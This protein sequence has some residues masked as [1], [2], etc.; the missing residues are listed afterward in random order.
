L[1]YARAAAGRII[2]WIVRFFYTEPIFRARCGSVGDRLSIEMLPDVTGHLRL[3][4]GSNVRFGG[5]MGVAAGRI[6]DDP[7]IVLG[8]GVQFGHDV[9]IAANKE[10]IVESGVRIGGGSRVLDTDG[11]PRNAALRAANLP[12]PPDEIRPVRIGQNAAIG[13]QS[14][15]LKG[16]SIGEGA[17]I[18]PGSVVVADVPAFSVAAGNPVRILAR[19]AAAQTTENP[20]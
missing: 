6:F 16:V 17:T 4:I 1:Y 20:S 3:D 13:A 11:H 19:R 10:V 12:P 15:V 9:T 5:H 2:W 14:F 18:G 7:R 8:D